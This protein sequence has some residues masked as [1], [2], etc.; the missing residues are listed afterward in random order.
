MIVQLPGTIFF[1]GAPPQR[2]EPSHLLFISV[3]YPSTHILYAT[4]LGLLSWKELSEE[5]AIV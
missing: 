4:I 3:T 2:K 5:L 1:G